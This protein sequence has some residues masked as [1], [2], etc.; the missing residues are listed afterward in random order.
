MCGQTA[1][2]SNDSVMKHLLK[3]T[4]ASYI[5]KLPIS[6][7]MF[8]FFPMSNMRFSPNNKLHFGLGL[9]TG[10]GAGGAW[11]NGWLE[12][13]LLRGGIYRCGENAG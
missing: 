4:L 11:H 9:Q 7:V 1:Y 5:I 13:V 8:N 2:T 3:N 6:T 10:G 12:C